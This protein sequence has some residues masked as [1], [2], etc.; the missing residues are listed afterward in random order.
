MS[1]DTNVTLDPF[2]DYDI[3]ESLNNYEWSELAPALVV[4][5]ITF[6][7]GLTGNLVIIASTLCPKLRPLPSTPTNIFLGGLASA[8]LILITFCI[9]VKIAKLFSYT[10]TMG[11][12]LC[13]SVHYM[14]SVSA[15]C[16]V[17]TLT[18]MSVERYYA[19]VHP[20]RAQYTCTI[21][22]ARRIVMV[23]WAASFLLAIPM[24][25]TQRH[26]AVGEKVPAFWCVRD[27]DSV[28]IWRLHELYM[29]LLVLVIPLV[30]MAF[31]YTAICWEIWLV[32]KRRY[33]MTSRHALSPTV[34]NNAVNG[35]SIAMTDRRRDGDRSRRSRSRRGDA[36]TEIESRTM[37]QVV[38]MLVAVVVL[39]AICWSPMLI[40][41]VLTSYGILPRLKHDTSKH[42][43]T[44]F[45][46]MAYFNS[47]INPIIYG[48]MSK[49]FRESF[50]A[51][52]CG[53]WWCC[54]RRRVYTP[55]VKRHPSVS[56][57]RTTS[58][59]WA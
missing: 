46:L 48:F 56:Q 47:C 22:Q 45:Q 39:F 27:S 30:V 43:N 31:C 34:N 7:L 37:K 29:L 35:E 17:L 2:L 3:N 25:F 57:T 9:P 41:N 14:Q 16:S 53:G 18:A 58:V 40:D 1:N 50:L 28:T 55:P 42:L 24:L 26:K 49:H 13:K 8:D 36:R 54:C 51:A 19:I 6:C 4:Y 5:S 12:F 44:I 32:M 23:T 10:W 33:H 38:K 52:A 20:M 21:S 59:R 11:L 15:I